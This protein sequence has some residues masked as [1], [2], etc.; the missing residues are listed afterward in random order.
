MLLVLL[1]LFGVNFFMQLLTQVDAI[2]TGNYGISKA[3]LYVLVQMPKNMY[4]YFP[5]A[6]LVGCLIGLGQLAARNELIAAQAA[7]MS[8]AEVTFSALRYSVFLLVFMVFLG[9]VV[10]PKIMPVFDKARSLWLQQDQSHALH[11]AW[12]TKGDTFLHFDSQLP[13]KSLSGVMLFKFKSGKL[14]FSE[15]APRALRINDSTWLLKNLK[16]SVFYDQKVETKNIASEQ[17]NYLIDMSAL[18]NSYS[19]ASEI[20][21]PALD[22]Q[23]KYLKS[24]GLSVRRL[25]YSYWQRIFTPL[26]SILMICIAVPFVFGSM[27]DSSMS[28]RVIVGLVF[29]FGFFVLNQVIGTLSLAMQLAPILSAGLPLLLFAIIYL[30]LVRKL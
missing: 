18:N 16:R 13:D 17:I 15:Y 29:G 20:A 25:Q 2:G 9:E 28:V 12:L 8:V 4:Q 14:L 11:G 1:L 30:R 6:A 10:A 21:L 7:G 22:E 5:I 19:F 27:R 3:L 23:I 24:V 26:V